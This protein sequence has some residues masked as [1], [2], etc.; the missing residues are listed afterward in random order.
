MN[1]IRVKKC[2]VKLVCIPTDFKPVSLI[3]AS[4]TFRAQSLFNTPAAMHAYTC[5]S[6]TG[7]IHVCKF[8]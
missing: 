6:T 4:L 2:E 1:V 8:L 7:I 5:L 3:S